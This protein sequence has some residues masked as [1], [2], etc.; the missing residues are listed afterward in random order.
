[1]TDA[2]L[3]RVE[4]LTKRFGSVVALD[5]VDLDVA[6]GE[7]H[8]VLGENG[9]GK[10]T[11]MNVLYGILRP[12]AGKLVWRGQD[13]RL[14]SSA[15]ARALG[16]AMVH[17]H[18]MLVPAL[19]VWE[20]IWLAHPDR[21]RFRLTRGRARRACEELGRRFRLDLPLDAKVEELP[22]G[23]R[24][25][26]EIAKALSRRVRLL[27]LDE[28]TAVLAPSEV[29]DLFDV[30]R[31]LTDGGTAVAFI[32]HKL[33]EALE[34]SDRITLLRR[35]RILARG[36]TGDTERGELTRRIVGADSVPS[37]DVPRARPAS[38]R[39]L[40]TVEN[41]SSHAGRVTVRDV[42]FELSGG[43]I[44]GVTG[45]DGNGQDEL[46][47]LM[48]G[49]ERPGSGRIRLGD[50][51][52]T[53]AGVAERWR[54]GL[55]VLPG[56]RAREGLVLDATVTENLALREFGAAWARR[57]LWIDPREHARRAHE[58]VDRFHVRVPSVDAPA[59]TLSGGNQQKLLV[60][61][62]LAANPSV[63]ILHNPLRG[64]DLAAIRE[65]RRTFAAL[66]DDGRAIIL[67]STELEEVLAIADRWAV[68]T[69]GRLRE[70]DR[71]D[72]E[73]LG[74][75]MLGSDLS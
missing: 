39:T 36:R 37:A 24:Q 42:S 66:R 34:I 23:A 69:G 11:L 27:I 64:L 19:S 32:S 29:G 28:P 25:R 57:G 53:A 74:A 75:M 48:A 1:M 62:E 49:M 30:I 5:Q 43:E 4:R 17:Q 65:L 9:A 3:L 72:A 33:D 46:V 54:R 56:D 16:I 22:V 67:F 59:A 61:R 35:G 47:R 73:L 45:V 40:L 52:V 8:A 7:V 51:D 12:D 50:T 38:A 26:V 10:T 68:M 31:R 58:L 55:A 70:A 13:V 15:D 44:L 20:N 2:T 41:L 6:A 18:F 71:P 60:A 14:R 21:P 63:L